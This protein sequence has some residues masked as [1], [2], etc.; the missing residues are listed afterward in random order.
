MADTYLA[1]SQIANNNSMQERMFACVTQEQQLQSIPRI[2]GDPLTWVGRNR[3][4]WASSPDWG[5]AW[6]YSQAAHPDDPDFDPGKDE[7]VITDGMILATVQKLGTH[8]E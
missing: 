2:T 6:A 4:I 7:A 8:P 1:I 5:S 3:Y